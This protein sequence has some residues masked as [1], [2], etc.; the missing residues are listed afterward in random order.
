MIHTFGGRAGPTHRGKHLVPEDNR[1]QQQRLIEQHL[2]EKESLRQQIRQR[3]AR[4]GDR[5][6]NCIANAAAEPQGLRMLVQQLGMRIS[7]T[8]E[9]QLDALSRFLS[10]Y[11]PS[12]FLTR[13]GA[14][15][16]RNEALLAQAEE[17]FAG[18]AHAEPRPAAPKKP[19]PPQAPAP[20]AGNETPRRFFDPEGRY[21]GPE[22][23][24][25]TDRRTG[26]ERRGRI[27]AVGRNQ[28]FGGDRRKQKRRH[29]DR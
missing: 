27:D 21:I 19:K 3:F 16:E 26:A 24:S 8:V 28:R 25:G 20:P 18:P 15:R 22:R 14:H 12:V 1:R 7:P 11:G 4:Y 29:T 2:R 10:R 6:C 17:A 13:I 9:D 5:V 23:R